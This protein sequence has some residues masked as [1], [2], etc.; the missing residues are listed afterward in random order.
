LVAAALAAVATA[1]MMALIASAARAA[2]IAAAL[3]AVAAAVMVTLI[4]V[5]AL[6]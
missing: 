2:L 3:A 1:V 5:A 6:V 4:A